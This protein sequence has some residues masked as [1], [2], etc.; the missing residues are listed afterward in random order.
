MKTKTKREAPRDQDLTA[1]SNQMVASNGFVAANSSAT[2]D[3]VRQYSGDATP[4]TNSFT[5]YWFLN[6][7]NPYWTLE[8][9]SDLNNFNNVPGL[10]PSH[11]GFFLLSRNVKANWVVLPP[12]VP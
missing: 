9:S 3:V 4:G 11:R 8:G 10:L 7:S 1:S 12:W 6:V 2:A 5:S